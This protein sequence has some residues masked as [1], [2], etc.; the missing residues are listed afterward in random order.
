MGFFYL[1]YVKVWVNVDPNADSKLKVVN[2]K[3]RY[4]L[5]KGEHKKGVNKP[6][7]K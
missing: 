3:K 7:I 4:L 6:N 1:L 2:N 5:Y